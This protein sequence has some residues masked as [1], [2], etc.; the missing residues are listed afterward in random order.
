MDRWMDRRMD[1]QNSGKEVA[2][3]GVLRSKKNLKGKKFSC[4]GD[5]RLRR[6]NDRLLEKRVRRQ[7]S[8]SV[9]Q[10]VLL[11]NLLKQALG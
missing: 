4:P 3:P 6:K 8:V 10:S 1:R 2:Y 5:L 9:F 7:E 11:A